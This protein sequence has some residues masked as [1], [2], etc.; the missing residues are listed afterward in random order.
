MCANEYLI[1][2]IIIS[3]KSATR[4]LT[5]EHLVVH[6]ER[7]QGLMCYYYNLE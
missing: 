4:Q 3:V 7:G 6:E 5:I 2:K 1:D